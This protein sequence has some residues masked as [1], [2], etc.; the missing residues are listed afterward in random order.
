MP[1]HNVTGG[2]KCLVEHVRLLVARGHHVIA[3]HRS[4]TAITAMPPWSKVAASQDVVCKLNERMRDVPGIESLDVVVVGI[5]HQV[6]EAAATFSCPVMYW[7]QGHEWVF[8]DPVRLLMQHHYIHQD[9]LFHMSMLLP[10]VLVSVSVA[11]HSI[12]DINF[13]RNTS[14]ICNGIDCERF[15]PMQEPPPPGTLRRVLLVGNPRLP[16]KGFD[17]AVQALLIVAG[18]IDLHITWICQFQPEE[19]LVPGLRSLQAAAKEFV[20]HVAPAQADIPRL[21]QGH[22]VFLFTSRYEA[23]G[24]PVMEAMACGVPAVTTD[25]QGVRTFAHDGDN[26]LMAGPLDAG[27]LAAAVLK[28]LQQPEFAAQLRRRG[29]ETAREYRPAQIADNLELLLYAL[30]TIQ[31][32]LLQLRDLAAQ[33]ISL[34]YQWACSYSSMPVS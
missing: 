23:W 14:L 28:V 11:I 30:T 22:E 15:Y 4:Q 29:L 6:A 12:L 17:I 32:Q 21:Y 9:R 8:G 10:V 1:H 2:M 5:F 13:G 31:P 25:C 27:R 16:L 33:D 18:H 34:A 19:H 24:L 3:L 7:E 26:C 20:C